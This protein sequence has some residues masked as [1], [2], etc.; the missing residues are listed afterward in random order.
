MGLIIIKSKIF[1]RTHD[2][3]GH[4]QD[5]VLELRSYLL[6]WQVS[7]CGV[8]MHQTRA[9]R[10][11]APGVLRQEAGTA[12]AEPSSE[13]QSD[14]LYNYRPNPFKH[15]VCPHISTNV[16]SVPGLG[17]SWYTSDQMRILN[18]FNLCIASMM[19]PVTCLAQWVALG[20]IW[21]CKAFSKLEK[22]GLEMRLGLCMLYSLKYVRV[23]LRQSL[24]AVHHIQWN[25]P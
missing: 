17:T 12:W 21:Y 7:C 22:F 5:P 6:Q 1:I 11:W 3:L 8:W 10:Y 19:Q 15:P 18:A 4:S 9:W 14:T 20:N 23:R 24:L 16:G 2:I 25:L 13:K